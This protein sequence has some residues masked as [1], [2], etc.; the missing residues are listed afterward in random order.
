MSVSQRALFSDTELDFP[1]GFRYA[2]ELLTE[3]NEQDLILKLEKLKFT[4]FEFHGFVGK[5]RVASFGWRYDFNR[6]GLQKTD[7]VPAFLGPVLEA[8][9]EFSEIPTSKLQQVLVTEYSPGAAIGWHKDRSVFG[10][11]VGVS[12]EASCIFRF[13]RKT[14]NAWERR[15]LILEPRSAYLLQGP[16]R[17]EW[18]HSIPPVERLRYSITLRTLKNAPDGGIDRP[19][20]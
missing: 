8:A 2:P 7:D 17:T 16:S 11:V 10:D 15:S 9:A 5:R 18:E 20:R 6:G 12:L 19:K 4:P 13:R 1:Q 14:G 3:A